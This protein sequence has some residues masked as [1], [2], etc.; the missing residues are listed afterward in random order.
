M[1]PHPLFIRVALATLVLGSIGAAEKEKRADVSDYPFWNAPKRGHVAPFVPGL[2]AVLDL[3]DA[4]KQQISAA[5]D[6]MQ[7]DAAV[8]AARSISKSDPSVTADERDKARAVVEA[9]AAQMHGK[10]SAVL[11]VEQKAMIENINGAY[12]EAAKQIGATY[13]EKVGAVKVGPEERKRMQQSQREEVDALF[14]SRLDEML[15]PEQKI[16]MADA[17]RWEQ[18]KG[19]RPKKQPAPKQSA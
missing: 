19:A 10:V 12:A 16:L 9:A 17:A 18:Q 4:Q 1:N 15:T 8:Q 13:Q 7:A 3:T 11:T 5:R 14:R 6:E 2:N